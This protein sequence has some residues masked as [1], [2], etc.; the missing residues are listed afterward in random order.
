[1]LKNQTRV[2]QFDPFYR[3]WGSTMAYHRAPRWYILPCFNFALEVF[4]LKATRRD[5]VRWDMRVLSRVAD[6][7]LRDHH[8]HDIHCCP[9]IHHDVS[10]AKRNR[11]RIH[12]KKD[13]S[14]KDYAFYQSTSSVY[15]FARDAPMSNTSSHTRSIQSSTTITAASCVASSV[16][17]CLVAAASLS[18]TMSRLWYRT[19]TR[20]CTSA[21]ER[22]I[23]RD[24]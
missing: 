1:M 12:F 2:P 7:P 3:V 17:K 20:N 19:E 18:S 10:P 15:R 14:E 24:A 4:K 16:F 8:A 22:R 5:T 13:V 6:L 9:T 11:K 23:S 21:S